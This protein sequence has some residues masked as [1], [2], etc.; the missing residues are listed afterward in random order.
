ML[1]VKVNKFLS[2]H[3]L[4]ALLGPAEVIVPFV[5]VEIPPPMTIP[6]G[7]RPRTNGP[8]PTANVDCGEELFAKPA[9]EKPATNEFNTCG[10]T[11]CV[12]CKLTNWLRSASAEANRGST[13][14][15]SPVPSS[16]V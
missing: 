16:T 1:S 6:P 7:P 2:F 12:S 4:D 9:R 3:T 13:N 14:G 11:M 8:V 5:V 15:I 10:D